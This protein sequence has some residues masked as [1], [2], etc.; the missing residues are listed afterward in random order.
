VGVAD[1]RERAATSG[2]TMRE[3]KVVKPCPT[4]KFD[5]A[6]FLKGAQVNTDMA[7]IIDNLQ[8]SAKRLEEGDDAGEAE[9]GGEEEEEEEVRFCVQERRGNTRIF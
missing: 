2:R 4:C 7:S 1:T 8:R 5:L 3:A 9:D 6:E